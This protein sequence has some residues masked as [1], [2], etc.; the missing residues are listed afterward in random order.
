MAESPSSTSEKPPIQK[1]GL[2]LL[3]PDSTPLDPINPASQI[4]DLQHPESSDNAP[5]TQTDSPTE[6]TVDETVALDEDVELRN[7]IERD[8]CQLTTEQAEIEGARERLEAVDGIE[9]NDLGTV[10]EGNEGEGSDLG[11]ADGDEGNDLGTVREGDGGEGNDLGTVKEGEVVEGNDLGSVREGDGDEGNGLGIVI[12]GDEDEEK[13]GKVSVED[14]YQNDWAHEEN[15]GNV[16]SKYGDGVTNF[17]RGNLSNNRRRTNY[18]MRPDAE[19][20]TFYM[21]FG[22]CKFGLNCKFNHPPRRKNQVCVICRYY[23]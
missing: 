4:V 13:D 12:K 17:D 11:K 1:L 14:E 9:G 19:D 22:S 18:P 3:V 16:A 23:L 8:L 7:A 15:D 5:V 10:R 20:C 6:V 2:G 21:K